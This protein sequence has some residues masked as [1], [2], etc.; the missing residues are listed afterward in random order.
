MEQTPLA[1]AEN[2]HSDH[3]AAKPGATLRWDGGLAY[4]SITGETPAENHLLRMIALRIRVAAEHLQLSNEDLRRIFDRHDVFEVEMRLS[5]NGQ[6]ADFVLVET[7]HHLQGMVGKGALKLVYPQDLLGSGEQFVGDGQGGVEVRAPAGASRWASAREAEEPVRKA[8]REFMTGET[9]SMSLK[10]QATGAPFAGSE[11]LVLCALREFNEASGRFFLR[12]ALKG[13]PAEAAH[14]KELLELI[15][16]EAAAALTEAGR[17][18]FD[19]IVHAAETNS[20]LTA[21]LDLQLPTNVVEGHLRALLCGDHTL[22][23]GDEDMTGRL[24]ALLETPDYRPT[25]CVL[26][27]AAAQ[28]QLE[29]SLLLPASREKLRRILSEL[30]RQGTP[31]TEQYRAILDLFFGGGETQQ[32]EDQ[33]FSRRESVL[34]ELSVALAAPSLDECG[35]AG[36]LGFYLRTLLDNQRIML[37]SALLGKLPAGQALPIDWFDRAPLLKPELER[38]LSQLMPTPGITRDKV[39]ENFWEVV[40]IL[41]EAKAELPRPASDVHWQARKEVLELAARA[42]T[43][44]GGVLPSCARIVFFLLPYT[45]ECVTPRLGVVTRKPVSVC[46][47]ELRPEAMAAGGVMSLEIFLKKLTGKAQPLQGLRVAIEGLGN[48]GKHVATSVL[49]KGGRIVAVSDSKGALLCPGGFGREELAI[50]IAHKN[51]GRRLDTL[52]TSPAAC[53]F[54]E[55]EGGTITFVPDPEKLH[56]VHADILVLAAIAGTVNKDNAAGI[57]FRVVCELTGAGVSGAG[58][59]ILKDRGIHVIPDNLASSG[60][61]LVSLAEMIQNSSGQNWDRSL[62]ANRLHQQLTRSFD[63]VLTL[64]ERHSVD[65]PTASDILALERMHALA[66]YREELVKAAEVLA[67]RLREVAAGEAV[68]IASDN[69]EDGVA[70]AAMLTSL[71]AAFT[72]GAEIGV[73]HLDAS[74]RSDAIISQ[75][76][77]AAGSAKPIRHVFVLDRALAL[78]QGG[79]ARIAELLKLVHLTIVNNNWVTQQELQSVQGDP[80][81]MDQPGRPGLVFISPQTLKAAGRAREFSTAL[82]LRELAHHMVEDPAT[83]AQLDW[84]AAVASCLDIPEE[85]SNEWVWFFAQFNPDRMLEA[86]KALRMVTR[87]GGFHNAVEALTSVKLPEHLES[88]P[89]WKQFIEQYFLLHD[90][91]QVLVDKIVVENRARP[92]TAH[93]FTKDEVSSPTPVAGDAANQL[94]LYHWISEHLSRR[95]NLGEKPIIVGQ[96][97]S[98]SSVPKAMGVR[99]RSPRGVDLME[100]GLPPEFHTAGLPNTAIATLPL[101]P[102]SSPE[103]EFQNL[104]DAIWMKTTHP[105]Y[106]AASANVTEA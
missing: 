17:I 60:G 82:T 10:S 38:R 34:R 31:S 43:S 19:R 98:D 50:I 96:L 27:K 12:S 57:H 106:L 71:L 16:N 23:I 44:A 79:P 8:M 77:A 65:M 54:A 83:L 58:K 35:E 51:S 3:A 99:I 74:L 15:M 7:Y 91:V 93:F 80:E 64:S 41:R 53:D 29:H 70:S 46:G 85:P 36:V 94:D 48:A 68:L 69:D 76:R 87:A 78:K 63:A 22:T 72:P 52:L 47:S 26:A 92:Y 25:R 84:Q 6:A 18:G 61:L 45:Y 33:L 73:R 56:E 62:E 95:G 42:I 4:R 11:G 5:P 30:P 9:L 24:R 90:R 1:P 104:V 21:G 88:H 14:D 37:E 39:K 59:R 81:W 100:V 49:Q 2:P 32:T 40:K 67:K 66:I 55:H 89:G 86:A 13:T 102:N 101:P 28:M 105:I 20:T 97:V 103:Q 75:V